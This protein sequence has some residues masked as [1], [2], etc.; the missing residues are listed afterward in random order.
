MWTDLQIDLET[1]GLPPDGAIVSIG[2]CFFSLETCEI[3]PTFSKNINLA[4][5]VR[6][7]G[8]I[9]PGTVLFWMRQPDRARLNAINDNYDNR[10][11]LRAFREFINEHSSE[12]TV[13]PWGN[14]ASFDLTL[15]GASYKRIGEDAPWKFFNERCFRT[16]RNAFPSV[17]YDPGEKG[18]DAH[19]ALAD[20]IFQARHLM[21]IKNRNKSNA[22]KSD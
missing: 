12:K 1:F 15:L 19:T 20:A 16:L 13:R 4:T 11:V 8:V 2:A 5:A 21:K 17:E 7:G 18:E 14:G 6:D 3:G 9:E 10:Q 22:R